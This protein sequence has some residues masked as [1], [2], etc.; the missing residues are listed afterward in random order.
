MATCLI[1]AGGFGKRVREILG[2]TPKPLAIVNGKPFLFWISQTL[3]RHGFN[4]L[5]FL[6]HFENERIKAF[7]NDLLFP[8]LRVDVIVEESPLG[9]AG[10]IVNALGQLSDIENEFFIVNGDSL[11]ITDLDVLYSEMSKNS[12]FSL[13]G[14]TMD[15]CSRYGTLDVNAN[16]NLVK[17]NEKSHSAYG[18]INSGVYFTNKSFFIAQAGSKL[19]LSLEYDFIPSL[20]E[21]GCNVKVVA[22]DDKPFIDIGTTLSLAAADDFIKT[23]F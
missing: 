9:T 22:Q 10:S 19:P 16:G 12:E 23:Y 7:A 11:V 1:L 8:G 20:L 4:R 17:F 21:K 2:S 15:D 5:I 14:I 18:L 13:L 6:A 3:Y